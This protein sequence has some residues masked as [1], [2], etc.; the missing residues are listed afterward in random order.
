MDK[1]L[2]VAD[3]TTNNAMK[4]PKA[5]TVNQQ[6]RGDGMDK[7]LQVA[8]MTTKN[9]MGFSVLGS[10]FLILFYQLPLR[11]MLYKLKFVALRILTLLHKTLI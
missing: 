3:M 10:S 9:A 6:V 7:N 1:N 4:A 2:Q 5:D 8:D 11:L